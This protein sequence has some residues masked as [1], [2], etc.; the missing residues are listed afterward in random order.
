MLVGSLLMILG[1]LR[2]WGNSPLWG[3]SLRAIDT[4][5]GILV[6]GAALLILLVAVVQPRRYR[7][8][9]VTLSGS[10]GCWLLLWPLQAHTAITRGWWE[11]ILGRSICC[12]VALAPTGWWRP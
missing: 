2:P 7:A 9:I 6:W 10:I 3:V 5:M 12:L 1:F 4:E 8:I 11:A